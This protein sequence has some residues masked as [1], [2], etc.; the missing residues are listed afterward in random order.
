MFRGLTMVAGGILL[1][2]SNAHLLTYLLIVV[3]FSYVAERRKAR[4]RN[5]LLRKILDHLGVVMADQG[6]VPVAGPV[7]ALRVILEQW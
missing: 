5:F 7:W 4:I 3:N 1:L 2:L 6:Q